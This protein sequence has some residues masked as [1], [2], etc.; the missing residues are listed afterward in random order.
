MRSLQALADQHGHC[1][2]VEAREII[3]AA[4]KDWK[5]DKDR[6]RDRRGAAA[7]LARLRAELAATGR[8]FSDSTDDTRR[9]PDA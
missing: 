3:R 4:V 2:E 7:E 9:H 8:V 5:S 1:V 6:A